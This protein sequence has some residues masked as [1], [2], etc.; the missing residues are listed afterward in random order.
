VLSEEDLKE[1]EEMA[2]LF[3]TEEEVEEITGTRR[4]SKEWKLAFRRG[5][6]KA[7]AALRK[8]IIS[9]ANDGSGPAQSMAMKMLEQQKRLKD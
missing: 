9:L 5:S 8:S 7:E 4:D 6:L 1:I 2:G 3:F